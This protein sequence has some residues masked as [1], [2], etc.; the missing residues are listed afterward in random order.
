MKAIWQGSISFGLV[1]IPVK[2]YSASEPRVVSFKLL[3]SKCKSPLHYKRFCPKCHKE[4][5]WTDV[6]KGLK[7]AKDKYFALT[8]EELE[9][10]RPEKTKFIEIKQFVDKSQV[11]PIYY[12]KYYYCVPQH[13][14]DKAYFLFREILSLT[15]KVAIATIIMKEKEHV[16]M[17]STYKNG[18]LLTTLVYAYEIRDINQLI[19][20][21]KPKLTVQEK[22]L[23][24]KLIRQ[25]ESDF[26]ISA[27]KDTFA[28]ELKNLIK[29]KMEGKE[30]KAKPIEKRKV[31]TLL[32]ALKASV[33]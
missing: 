12:D 16:C 27:F 13:E 9:S 29:M 5:E 21:A 17:I 33:K 8:K 22:N 2:L 24:M 26:H 7:V 20:E 6:I 1:S 32:D 4:I 30:I 14:K 31:K 25:M 23:A 18:L 10:I 11:D 28:E 3:C 19:G 15:G